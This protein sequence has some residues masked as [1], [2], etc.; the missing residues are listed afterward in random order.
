MGSYSETE[1]EL[2]SF[3][4]Q[5]SKTDHIFKRLVE[6]I[7]GV[8][9][10]GIYFKHSTVLDFVK[11]ESDSE[12]YFPSK[13]KKTLKQLVSDFLDVVEFVGEQKTGMFLDG[14][15]AALKTY[16]P[17]GRDGFFFF[18][19][20]TETDRHSHWNEITSELY[21]N[22]QQLY[23][24]LFPIVE[25][26]RQLRTSLTPREMEIVSLV[27]AGKSNTQIADNIGISSHTVNGYLRSIYLKTN[28]SDRISLSFY[29]YHHGLLG[30][31]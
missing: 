18:L 6:S 2:P 23:L 19:L 27:A 12:L 29:S 5:P 11:Y 25:S 31:G 16:G 26:S 9:I 4:T 20:E 28:T 22:A 13:D 7:S 15:Y 3:S 30:D 17:Y 24:D 14:N 8:K 1:Y 10:V 21:K